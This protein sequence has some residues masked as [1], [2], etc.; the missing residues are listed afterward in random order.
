MERDTNM[1]Q[2]NGKTYVEDKPHSL[3]ELLE[4]IAVLRSPEGCPW[5][6]EQTHI[7]LKNCLTDE[8]NE[9][10]EAIDHED[11][12]NL[13]EELGDLLLQ[14]VMHC[15]IAKEQGRFDFFD[16]VN[17]VTDKMIRRHPHVFG[18]EPRP[19]TPEESLVLWR[20]IKQKEKEMKK[21]K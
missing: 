15:Q 9:V 18:D 3:Q 12:E 1:K 10:L 2:F 4:V 6:R 13:C 11:D 17:V 19:E 20:K 14:V 8:A 21:N 16:V 7:S 5:D